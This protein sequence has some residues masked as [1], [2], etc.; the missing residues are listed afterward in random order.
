MTRLLSECNEIISEVPFTQMEASSHK[1]GRSRHHACRSVVVSLKLLDNQDLH[2][3]L[4]ALS[5]QPLGRSYSCQR[6]MVPKAIK[7]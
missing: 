7:W 4:I 2:L 6:W 3:D 5:L 1:N